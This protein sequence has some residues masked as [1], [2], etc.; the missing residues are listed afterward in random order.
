MQFLYV[1]FFMFFTASIHLKCAFFCLFFKLHFLNAIFK[2]RVLFTFFKIKI[3]A[4]DLFC[5]HFFPPVILFSKRTGHVP[6]RAEC[7]STSFLVSIILG[8]GWV[9][10]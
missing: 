4:T 7:D 3:C 9:Q 2:M 10:D 1:I 5:I 6:V 8:M